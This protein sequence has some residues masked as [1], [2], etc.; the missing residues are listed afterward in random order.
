MTSKAKKTGLAGAIGVLLMLQPAAV[1]S[2]YQA[3]GVLTVEAA[4]ASAT[5][6]QLISQRGGRGGGGGSSLG[7]P[8]EVVVDGVEDGL[9]VGEGGGLLVRGRTALLGRGDVLGAGRP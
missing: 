8:V 3:N 4:T 5:D 1:L 9:D 7:G 2:A 6:E